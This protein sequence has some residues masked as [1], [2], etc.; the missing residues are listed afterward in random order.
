V[1]EPKKFLQ[2]QV[3]TY[4]RDVVVYGKAHYPCNYAENAGNAPC[5]VKQLDDTG[6]RCF[7]VFNKDTDEV[8]IKPYPC[9]NCKYI[10]AV[11]LAKH[12]LKD[13]DV[14]IVNFGNF[15]SYLKSAEVIIIDE[16]DAFYKSIMVGTKLK[17]AEQLMEN[18][19]KTIDNELFL[20]DKRLE[21]LVN[22]SPKDVSEQNFI[23]R[24]YNS[25][26]DKRDKLKFFAEHVDMCFQYEHE[27]YKTKE[28]DFYVELNPK[29]TEILKEKIFSGKVVW[30]VTATPS[31]FKNTPTV[32]DYA[33]PQRTRVF[34][35]PISLMT[36]NYCFTRNNQHVF[37]DCAEFIVNMN[38]IFSSLYKSE[39]AIIH[40][41]NL[42]HHAKELMEHMP[43]ERCIVH[44]SGKL[45]ETVEEFRNSDKRFLLIV[46]A[47]HGLDL[48]DMNHQFIL[49]VP[50]ASEDNRIKE[51]KKQMT[52]DEFS[53]FYNMDAVNRLVQSC[54][55][56]GRGADSF[57]CTFIMDQK[58]REVY[59]KFKHYL[60]KW[61]VGKLDESVY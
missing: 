52:P 54:G 48:S 32:I 6:K 47:D 8:T 42:L 29:Y 13:N 57:G 41:G 43:K 27:N 3:S 53:F 9:I 55:R 17:Y 33:V 10:E 51:L 7:Y 37:K 31:D 38:A 30:T 22:L 61:F 49:K 60:P 59:F 28:K 39:K 5:L 2:A 14:L 35:T 24:E 45:L 56:A 15:W 18:V 19:Q 50:F 40:T 12:T 34:Y 58:F 1:I 21:Q 44:S 20:I 16:A 11:N 36:S 4:Y 25:V 26:R 46:G 23:A